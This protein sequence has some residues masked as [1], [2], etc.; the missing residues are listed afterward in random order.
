[1]ETLVSTIGDLF[2]SK[3]PYPLKFYLF[4]FFRN[5]LVADQETVKISDFGLARQA[6]NDFYVMNSSSTI[7]VRWEAL[8]CLI[9]RKYSHKSDVWSFGVTIWE[10]FAFGDV[11]A[12]TGCQDFFKYEKNQR[13]DFRVSI[14]L[15]A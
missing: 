13:Q 8:E 14:V 3:S 12:L 10:M 1:M 9:H 6:T 15:A 4:F 11:P 5:I 2:V 7:P